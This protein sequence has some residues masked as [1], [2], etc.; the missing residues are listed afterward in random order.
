[1]R[2]FAYQLLGRREYS[3]SELSARLQKKWPEAEDIDGL[4]RQLAEENLVSDER[5]VESFLRSRIQRHQ[6]PLKIRAEL[7]RRGV[8]DSLISDALGHQSEVWPTLAFEWLDRQQPGELDLKQKQK[9][10]RRLINRGFSHSQAMDAV[11]Q[12]H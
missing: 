5:F 6:G 10:Y 2:A 1:M 9:Y 7:R 3:L 11:N 8:D 12:S 4:V